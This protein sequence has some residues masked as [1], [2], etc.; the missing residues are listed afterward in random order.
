MGEAGQPEG[1][2]DDWLYVRCLTVGSQRVST[3]GKR[4]SLESPP[5]PS[6]TNVRGAC[7]VC[8]VYRCLILVIG[9]CWREREE[10]E[11]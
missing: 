5:H 8:R 10:G 11:K 7:R 9:T 3:A 2:V 1:R 4:F 6:N